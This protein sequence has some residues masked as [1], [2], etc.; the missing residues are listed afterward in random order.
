LPSERPA[1]AA[2]SSGLND[3]VGALA[4]FDLYTL[5]DQINF[6]DLCN[7]LNGYPLRFDPQA[8]STLAS[9]ETR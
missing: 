6:L 8:D 3:G 1:I 5:A 9:W 7:A 4:S 2:A